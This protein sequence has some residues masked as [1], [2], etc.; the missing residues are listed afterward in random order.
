MPIYVYTKQNRQYS[1]HIYAYS[2]MLVNVVHYA[3]FKC[4]RPHHVRQTMPP[5]YTHVVYLLYNSSIG[6]NECS[7]VFIITSKKSVCICFS[8]M[9]ILHPGG[10]QMYFSCYYDKR[11]IISEFIWLVFSFV[12]YD[13]TSFIIVKLLGHAYKH[14]L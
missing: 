6:I 12:L 14:D 13:H 1:L 11:I 2:N 9:T 8:R 4:Y 3:I 5:L 10:V 7:N